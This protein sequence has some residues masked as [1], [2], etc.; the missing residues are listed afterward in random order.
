MFLSDIA[1]GYHYEINE[2]QT[3]NT[4]ERNFWQQNRSQPAKGKVKSP[5]EAWRKCNTDP[6]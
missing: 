2:E 5:S 6:G 4:A 1:A 3:N